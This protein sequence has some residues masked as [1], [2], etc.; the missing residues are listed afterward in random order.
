MKHEILQYLYDHDKHDAKYIRLNDFLLTLTTHENQKILRPILL[1]LKDENSIEFDK[2][3]MEG[4]LGEG[5][6]QMVYSYQ[7]A[8]KKRNH[9]HSFHTTY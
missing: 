9:K 2:T 6:K 8:N 1:Q 5:E 4:H 7:L 3:S